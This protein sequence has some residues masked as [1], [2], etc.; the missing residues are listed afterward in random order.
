LDKIANKEVNF[1][2]AL[3]EWGQKNRLELSFT[4][5]ESFF[6]KDG[7]SVFQTKVSLSGSCIGTGKGYSK[8]E[9]QQNAAKAAIRKIRT[10][11]DFQRKLL[12]LKRKQKTK[13]ANVA[14]D[15]DGLPAE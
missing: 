2:S 7:N 13:E 11:R 9:S 3:I 10:D 14:P 5:I 1:K 8:K 6:D 15:F 4:L 12:A